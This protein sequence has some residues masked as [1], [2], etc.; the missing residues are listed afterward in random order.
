MTQIAAIRALALLA[1]ASIPT[2]ALAQ[3]S[4]PMEN[5]NLGVGEIVVTAT[6]RSESINNIG[7]S[8]SA[9]SGDTLNDRGL[10]ELDEVITQVPGL[11]FATSQ[12][13]TPIITFRGVGFNE[14]S[15]GVYPATSLY[16][17]EVPL[18]FPA[19]AAHSAF[20]LERAEVLK[21]PQGVLFGQNSTGGAVNFI[22]AK[23]TDHFSAGVELGYGRFNRVEV[24]AFASGP[25]SEKVGVRLAVQNSRADAW[26]KSVTRDEKNGR[27]EYY[28]GRFTV[29]IDPSDSVRLTANL[30]GWID[31][32]DPL[33]MQ[34]VAA[35][36][37]RWD[38]AP[39]IAASQF[40][41][42]FSPEKPRYADWSPE[43]TPRGDR[44]FWQASLRSEFE[45]GD[46]ANLTSIL[47]H[48]RY[49]QD[50]TIDTDGSRLVSSDVL[51]TVG[52]VKTTFAELRL[53]GE[54]G[55]L[56][57]LVGG[58][59]EHTKTH[60]NLL[61]QFT[62]NTS[63]RPQTLFISGT[64]TIN[65][66]KIES[67]AAFG[68]VDFKVTDSLTLKGGARYTQT[69]IDADI[70]NSDPGNAPGAPDRSGGKN[71]NTATLFNALATSSGRPFT[72]LGIGDCFTLDNAPGLGIPVRFL[73]RLKEDNVSWR[74]G[75]DY[76]LNADALIY[77]NVSRGYKAGSYPT[78]AAST[79]A[80]LEPVK[81]ESVTAFEAGL[82]WSFANKRAHFNAAAF[83]YDYK[84]KQVRN[85]RL[86][87]IFGPLPALV[88][89]PKSRVWG[90]E[91][92]LT[93][94]VLEGLTL[95]AAGTYLNTKVKSFVGFDVYGG[96]NVNF[97]G[98]DLSYA[99]A[100]T[101]SLGFDYR[102][103]VGDGYLFTGANLMGQTKSDAIIGAGSTVVPP[104]TLAAGYGKS[105]TPHYFE[106]DGYAT[107]D[108]RLGYEA[109]EGNW[110]VMV[111]G[112]NIT[113]EYYYTNVVASS[114]GGARSIGRPATYGI[115]F[116]VKY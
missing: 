34:F 84:D 21:G 41:E 70:C 55:P 33:A 68:N 99:P 106:I 43:A 44:D 3:S 30:N 45:L 46:A 92:E 8:I 62:D 15:L 79:I 112:K 80:Q 88:N 114:E 6:K 2:I 18:P 78:I 108:A 72:Q 76:K 93:A 29:Q 5:E 109:E 90:L 65:D 10:T 57:W 39:A 100:F 26:Q 42:P 23:P 37:K 14:S 83:Y 103:P 71:A 47:A 24:N 85:M 50:M 60:E 82:K 17:D 16:V 27:S 69:K 52:D 98:D 104:A 32:S 1:T 101:Y 20:D 115:S 110:K 113:N 75:V 74:V 89:V 7:L 102:I 25:V 91:G 107:V 95:S 59:Y 35:S 51:R 56:R 28:V 11:T 19:M 48:S 61:T 96:P 64:R 105:I 73:D 31:K 54:A 4:P 66:Q 53:D 111:F 13:G 22:A 81:Q 63:F 77:A 36:P 87:A 116:G 94:E 12:Y 67:F 58:N 38:Q 97:A 49:N 9:I 40:A 86:T